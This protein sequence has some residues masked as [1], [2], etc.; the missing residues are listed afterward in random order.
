MPSQDSAVR[1]CNRALS[2]I[3]ARSSITSLVPG[4]DQSNEARQCIL[5]YDETREEVLREARWN[6]A[7]RQALLT[8]LKIAPVANPSFVPTSALVF[9]P[10]MPWLYEF[11]Y[12]SDC[13]QFQQ[14]VA[15]ANPGTLGGVPLTTGPANIGVPNG[16]PGAIPWQEMTDDVNGNTVTVIACNFNPV[17][18]RY[19]RS[20]TD[21]TLFD[22]GFRE[23]LVG[24]LASKLAMP[25]GGNLQLAQAEIAKGEAAIIKARQQDANEANVVQDHVPDFVQIRGRRGPRWGYGPGSGGYG[26]W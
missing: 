10:F 16:Y 20:I 5:L 24:R 13:L 9:W 4:Q 26:G 11:A 12:P 17:Q 21:P 18:G 15:G 14:I 2:A 6:F 8:L 19:T 3:A 22:N 7:N 23:A 1:I 25:L